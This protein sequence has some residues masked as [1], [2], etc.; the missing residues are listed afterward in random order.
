MDGYRL[1]Q[2]RKKLEAL[3]YK[4]P[5][6]NGSAVLVDKLVAD[7]L[8]TTDSYRDLKLHVAKKSQDV[9]DSQ[10]KV[11]GNDYHAA[12]RKVAHKPERL[13]TRMSTHIGGWAN[14]RSWAVSKGKQPAAFAAAEGC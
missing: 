11:V 1:S 8:H 9:E 5:L 13:Q 4:E 3:N 14:A 2:L 7:L 6:D 10:H 12:D